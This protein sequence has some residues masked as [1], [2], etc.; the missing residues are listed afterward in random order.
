MYRFLFDK[1]GNAKLFRCL[2]NA[3]AIVIVLDLRLGPQVS[4]Q[5]HP[6]ASLFY[7]KTSNKTK[8]KDFQ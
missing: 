3:F 6:I 4:I 2:D 1:I 7:L 5:C 8:S